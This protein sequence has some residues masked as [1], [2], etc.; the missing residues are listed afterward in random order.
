[1]S[2]SLSVWSSSLI[3]DSL[4]TDANLILSGGPLSLRSASTSMESFLTLPSFPM[5]FSSPTLNISGSPGIDDSFTMEQTSPLEKNC[6]QVR[7]RQQKQQLGAFNATSLPPSQTHYLSLLTG[8]K[9]GPVNSTQM[10]KRPRL[11][12]QE[13]DFL[14]HQ[15]IQQLLQRKDSLLLQGHNQ[16]LQS[17]IQQNKM[18]SQQQQKTLQ[19]I[20][21]FQGVEMQHQHQQMRKELQQQSTH[22]ISAMHPSDTAI[23]SRRLVQYMYHQQHHPPVSFMFEQHSLE[24]M[25][26]NHGYQC[27][28]CHYFFSLIKQWVFLFPQLFIS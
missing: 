23:C 6:R 18:Q 25:F 12:I 16:P 20:Q 28:Y 7:K 22:E 21:Q 13:E 24:M 11:D 14:C 19:P 17:W 2:P 8:I 26:V 5:S 9:Q 27:C 15:M 3:I 10:P 4:S 1:M